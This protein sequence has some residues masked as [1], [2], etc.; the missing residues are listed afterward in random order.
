MTENSDT[1]DQDESFPDAAAVI[2]AFGGVRPMAST[3]GIAATTIQGWKSR[4][5]V[6]EPRRQEVRDAAIAAGI[7]LDNLPDNSVAET[8]PETETAADPVPDESE[9][10][11]RATQAALPAK[12]GGQGVAW[13]A[14]IVAAAAG[15][16]LVTQPKWAPMVHGPSSQAVPQEIVT[17]LD[18][19]E[20]RPS[21]P[22]LGPVT[23]R[24]DTLEA[25]LKALPSEGG[26][27]PELS[28]QMDQLSQGLARGI[29]KAEQLAARVG[30]SERGAAQLRADS[31]AAA[32]SLKADIASLRDEVSAISDKLT[33]LT[34]RE[35]A[36]AGRTTGLALA[37]VSLERAVLD[38]TPFAGLL[39]AI[40]RLAD[41][42]PVV[43]ASIAVLSPDAA[44]GIPTT[45]A[46]VKRFEGVAAT[47]GEPLWAETGTGWLDQIL[48]RVDSVIAVRRIED[49]SG[50]ILPARR[51]EQAVARGDL[52]AAV[53]ALED[54]PGPATDWVQ[55]AKR[56]I[57]AEK[58][59]ASLRLH[60]VEMLGKGM[61]AAG[62]PQ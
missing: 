61:D 31:L 5:S 4:G 53:A 34:A 10:P 22:A 19:L 24:L 9:A 25:A 46:L 20:A 23:A 51:A 49:G 55:D 6:P 48:K 44:S 27:S 38:G 59:V 40:E 17:R 7:D 14:L 37:V 32:D 60:A 35:A 42:D 29:A 45:A 58:A 12:T 1:L 36:A 16:A 43:T 13:L 18:A 21:A 41:N 56:R 30:E 52:P 11:V 8:P 50:N 47:L 54:A 3:L 28:A 33:A 2:E 62:T 57:A 39:T 15:V 26:S